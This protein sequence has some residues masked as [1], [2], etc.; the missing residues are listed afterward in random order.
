MK[1][2]VISR[3]SIFL[4]GMAMGI[5]DI[6]PG[7]SGGTIAIIT[8]VYEEFLATLNNI[9]IKLL[10]LLFKGKIKKVW[11]K[12]NLNFLSYL[13]LGIIS[14]IIILSHFI[15]FL[16]T[17]YPVIV[18][19]FFFG[20]ILAGIAILFREIKNWNLKITKILFSSHLYFF[21]FG[22]AI[23]I[24]VQTLKPGINETNTIYLFFC[25]MISITAMLLPGV[26]GAY[27]L[28]LLGAYETLLNTLKEVFKFNSEYFLNFFSFIMGA[29]LSIKLFSRLLTWAYKNHK[30]NTL[31]CL[32][33]FMIGSLP[34]LW[35]W[36]TEQFSNET[37]LS[38]LYVPNG[39]FLNIEFIKGLLFIIIGIIFVLIL[40]YISKKNATKK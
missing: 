12:Y 21:V 26:S 40:E 8:G 17:Q 19:S 3:F 25:G 32:I 31:L 34:T 33:G 10:K 14:S 22:L 36:K 15:T 6:I 38:N 23:A 1:R 16:I 2:H 29:L 28:V 24:L 20:L 18:W 4:K 27:I 13:L 5:A 11:K 37:F 35:P 39:Y 30:D 9:D 7:V